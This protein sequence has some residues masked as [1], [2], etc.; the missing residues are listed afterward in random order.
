[1]RFTLL[2]SI[3][4]ELINVNSQ[5]VIAKI[6]EVENTKR[7]ERLEK[8][9]R[10]LVEFQ[11][12]EFKMTLEEKEAATMVEQ[13]REEAE[14]QERIE[15]AEFEMLEKQFQNE[16]KFAALEKELCGE[17]LRQKNLLHLQK[18]ERQNT[19]KG[20]AV[21]VQQHQH[22]NASNTKNI[23]VFKAV[24]SPEHE[25]A[26]SRK[27]NNIFVKKV[28]FVLKE[29]DSDAVRQKEGIQRKEPRQ[30]KPKPSMIPKLFKVLR[31]TQ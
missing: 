12:M 4:W 3:E 30:C 26:S 8:E 7:V 23:P 24:K 31:R 28:C 2:N 14:P 19:L 9:L 1:M 22:Q 17:R 6:Q 11:V 18:Q 27:Q 10:E 20:N 13:A 5:L 25:G 21:S 15:L 16:E 29:D